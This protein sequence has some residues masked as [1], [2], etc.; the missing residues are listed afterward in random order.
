VEITVTKTALEGV[1]LVDT[2]CN[3]D[4]RGFFMEVWNQRDYA[5]AGLTMTFVQQSHSR[6]RRGVLRG[7]HYQDMRAPLGKLI[8]CTVGEIFDVAVDLRVGSP[9][10]GKFVSINL[11][12]DNKRQIYVPPGFAHGFEAL[13]DPVEVQYQ[14]TGFYAPA[15]EA[16]VAWNDPDIGIP[17]PIPNPEL[18]ARDHKGMS[19]KEYAAKP[20]FRYG[21]V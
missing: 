16:S 14:Q 12:A 10:F 13:S 1:V 7:L 19:L 4:E 15:A 21:A 3:E 5:R 6:S 9:T 18:S 11:S 8:R 2:K 20:A 17:W